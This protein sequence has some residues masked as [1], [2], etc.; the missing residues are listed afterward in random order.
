MK[1]KKRRMVNFFTDEE[2]MKALRRHAR[3][4][5]EDGRA[6][7]S[8]VIREAIAEYL[9]RHAGERRAGKW[10]SWREGLGGRAGIGKT[11]ARIMLHLRDPKRLEQLRVQAKTLKGTHR[12]VGRVIRKAIDEYLSAHEKERREYLRRE[13][14]LMR[15]E[16]R[17][18]IR[19]G[20]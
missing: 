14:S 15:K 16:R 2:Q 7:V 6:S 19:R 18:V 17:K 4:M 12:T 10:T 20:R 9:V 11:P 3:R 13:R 5:L 8:G 1:L